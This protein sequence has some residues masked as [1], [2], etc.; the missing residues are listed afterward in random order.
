M[1]VLFLVVVCLFAV[2]PGCTSAAE[3]ARLRRV[4]YLSLNPDT[5]EDVRAAIEAGKI[6]VGMSEA[7]AQASWGRPRFKR[8]RS[9][10]DGESLVWQYT[11]TVG[12][13]GGGYVIF[14]DMELIFVDGKIDSWVDNDT[15]YA[16]DSLRK[17]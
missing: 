16:R 6:I 12:V 4:E 8:G 15:D 1:R 11:R 7:E 14:N 10:S 17:F 2:T 13:P 9:T 5:T 3:K